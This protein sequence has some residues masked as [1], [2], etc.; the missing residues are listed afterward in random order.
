MIFNTVKEAEDKLKWELSKYTGDDKIS[1]RRL[2][3]IVLSLI[4][5][6]KAEC[7]EDN[8]E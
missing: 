4:E 3:D 8:R 1:L 6:V 5:T 7:A 2:M